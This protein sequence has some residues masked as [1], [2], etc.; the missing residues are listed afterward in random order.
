[1]SPDD[2]KEAKRSKMK[3]QL[4]GDLTKIMYHLTKIECHNK[5]YFCKFCGDLC[6]TRCT[7]CPKKPFLHD[8]SIK[9]QCKGRSCFMN[10]D[11]DLYFGL[12]KDDCHVVGVRPSNWLPPTSAHRNNKNGKK[13][14]RNGIR[15]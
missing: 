11:N 2:V 9:G 4:C 15:D 14:F 6:Y 10:Y 3:S 7:I 5:E 8:F 1:M 12:A 13:N